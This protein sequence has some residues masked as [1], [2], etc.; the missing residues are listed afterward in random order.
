MVRQQRCR[1]IDHAMAIARQG[2]DDQ[3]RC[4]RVFVSN[5]G[6]LPVEVVGR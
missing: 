5:N 2:A 6:E 1:L 4:G 3:V